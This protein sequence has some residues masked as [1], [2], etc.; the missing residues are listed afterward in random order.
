MADEITIPKN[1]QDFCKAVARLCREHKLTNFSGTYRPGFDDPW[2]YTITFAW[3]EGRHG[4]AAN[5]IYITSQADVRTKI[6]AE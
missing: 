5:R 3:D 2:R 6:D 4:V 1:H